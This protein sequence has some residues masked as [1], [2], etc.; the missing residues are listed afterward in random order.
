MTREYLILI[1][2]VRVDGKMS[3]YG[4]PGMNSEIIEWCFDCEEA[5]EAAREIFDRVM[6]T[7]WLLEHGIHP[8]N[9]DAAWE[10]VRK[11]LLHL[12]ERCGVL[13]SIGITQVNATAHEQQ[14][15][16]SRVYEILAGGEK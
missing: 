15:I 8:L 3:D 16:L 9:S 14:N 13:T 5:S 12:G 7:G 10:E 4:V 6:N 11:H 1:C 2:I